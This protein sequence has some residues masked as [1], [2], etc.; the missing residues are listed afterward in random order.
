[1]SRFFFYYFLLDSSIKGDSLDQF[2]LDHCILGCGVLHVE[3]CPSDL[4]EGFWER[5]AFEGRQQKEVRQLYAEGVQYILCIWATGSMAI[6]G[7][8][9]NMTCAAIYKGFL[10][11]L[12]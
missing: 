2:L 11:G 4:T 1:M 9:Y 3:G 5:K 12:T 8:K 6:R 10:S 7:N